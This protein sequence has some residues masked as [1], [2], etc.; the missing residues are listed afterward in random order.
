MG[1]ELVLLDVGS[2][3]QKRVGLGKKIVEL[4]TF[5]RWS[6][7]WKTIHPRPTCEPG[8]IGRGK[9]KEVKG[10]KDSRGEGNPTAPCEYDRRLEKDAQVQR[11]VGLGTP[12]LPQSKRL[13]AGNQKK[14]SLL[15]KK[16]S[17]KV[18]K[19]G[20]DPARHLYFRGSFITR[21]TG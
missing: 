10:V 5:R 1:L 2:R 17:K 12:V 13:R 3:V 9:Q 4:E 18:L 20:G 21:T 15:R 8:R 7:S 14:G 11:E 19:Q 6:P 16:T